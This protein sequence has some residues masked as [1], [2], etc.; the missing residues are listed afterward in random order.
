VQRPFSGS[1]SDGWGIWRGGMMRRSLPLCFLP[2]GEAIAPR[3]CVFRV[4]CAAKKGHIVDSLIGILPPEIAA[5]ISRAFKG[6]AGIC[7]GERPRIIGGR[8][9]GLPQR[10]RARRENG[11]RDCGDRLFGS[12]VILGVSLYMETT[13]TTTTKRNLL[14]RAKLARPEREAGGP[15]AA[16]RETGWGGSAAAVENV[17]DSPLVPLF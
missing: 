9:S 17:A 11:C 13:T 15:Q 6:W 16:S 1:N 10:L 14:R 5:S 3:N 2:S 4:I 12:K 8:G 7:S